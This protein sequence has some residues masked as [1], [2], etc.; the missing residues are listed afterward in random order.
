MPFPSSIHT[1]TFIT[2]RFKR[3]HQKKKLNQQV[4]AEKSSWCCFACVC[5][6]HQFACMWVVI[7]IVLWSCNCVPVGQRWHRILQILQP[8]N[9]TPALWWL[10]QNHFVTLLKERKPDS[11]AVVEKVHTGYLIPDVPIRKKAANAD[12]FSKSLS[13]PWLSA[14]NLGYKSTWLAGSCRIHQVTRKSGPGQWFKASTK[15][16]FG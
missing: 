7:V 5:G 12:S 2:I 15:D 11:S 1:S 3:L 13:L 6:G 16:T 8:S 14:V 9:R 4:L 10:H